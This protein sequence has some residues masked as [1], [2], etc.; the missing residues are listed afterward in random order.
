M[1]K[2]AMKLKELSALISTQKQREH[3]GI[4]PQKIMDFLAVLQS[5]INQGVSKAE[6]QLEMPSQHDTFF[7]AIFK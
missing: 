2:K 4:T 1:K 3:R 5:W 6:N 7:K